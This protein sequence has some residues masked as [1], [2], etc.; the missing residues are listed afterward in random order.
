MK[1]AFIAQERGKYP[2][3]LMCRVL[4]V[5][6]AGF[7]AA[8]TRPPSAHAQQDEVLL[9][10]IERIFESSRQRYG[11]PRIHAELRA[12]GIRCGKKR[13]ARLMRQAALRA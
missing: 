4:G 10:D 1:Y 3:A 8:Q 6:R 5:S 13:V 7:Y 11:S 12:Q 9:R 2:V